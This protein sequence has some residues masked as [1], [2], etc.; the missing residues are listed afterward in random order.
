MISVINE[1]ESFESAAAAAAQER[2]LTAGNVPASAA[3]VLGTLTAWTAWS[4]S[5]RRRRQPPPA[6]A[7][8]RRNIDLVNGESFLHAVF[9]GQCAAI[10][11]ID[12]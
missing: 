1:A 12:H 7:A 5:A 11:R 10:V 3:P 6:G 2:M 4:C 8:K 9:N